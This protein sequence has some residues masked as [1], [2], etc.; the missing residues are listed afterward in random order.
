MFEPANLTSPAS[1]LPAPGRSFPQGD[2]LL[3]EKG[4]KLNPDQD[5]L[6]ASTYYRLGRYFD[7]QG[8]T[9]EALGLFL[10]AIEQD[11]TLTEAHNDLGSLY[12]RQGQFEAAIQHYQKALSLRPDFVEARYNLGNTFK[13]VNQWPEAA[14]HARK[15]IELDPALAEAY[16]VLG[17]ALYEQGNLDEAILNWDQALQI[18]EGFTVVYYNLGIAYYKKDQLDQAQDYCLKAVEL[19]PEL[20]EAHYNLGLVYF[21]KGE[22]KEAIRS[23]QRTLQ[24]DS[25]YL[26]AYNNM[27]SAFQENHDLP[28]ALKCFQKAIEIEPE[29]QEAHWNH[30]LCLLLSGDFEQ[31]WK[32]YQWRFR[33]PTLNLNRKFPQPTWAGEPLSGKRL[34]IYSEQGYGDT[35]QFIRYLPLVVQRVGKV[36]LEC[37][38]DLLSILCTL[39][40]IEQLVAY[41]DP[42]PDFDVQ[43]PLLN[44]PDIFK[45]QLA[46]I[47]NRIPYLAP[48]PILVRKWKDR[49]D[50]GP[51]GLKVGLVWAG[52]PTHRNNKRRSM[53]LENLLP[54]FHIPDVIFF[55][56]QK[57]EAVDQIP[58]L[59]GNVPVIDLSQDLTDFSETAALIENLDLV[60]S[61]DTA[62]AHLAGALGKPV[63]TLLPYAPDWRWLLD[64]ED[65]PWYPTMRLFRQPTPG[66][67]DSV[68]KNVKKKVEHIKETKKMGGIA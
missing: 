68:I 30:A 28:R 3:S 47:P 51:G 56:L 50:H 33:I 5:T 40:G 14:F 2:L 7:D 13:E 57:G 45:T 9:D 26:D 24:I 55:S 1:P 63:W 15:A 23:W 38:K 42:L 31:G 18:K 67:W 29:F 53:R 36:I 48:D 65:S 22:H 43:C 27:G 66:D 52:R 34:L 21:Q 6:P 59:P 16:Y 17:I 12:Q 20:A 41:Q 64:C 54:L 39:E 62:V 11:D 49:L 46:T 60:L 35:F 32:E 61:V 25:G 19:N 44:L 8:R 4:S 58:Q 10:K 37:P